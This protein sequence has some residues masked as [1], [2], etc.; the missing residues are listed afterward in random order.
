MHNDEQLQNQLI[1]Q[2]SCLRLHKGPFL[3]YVR[4][5]GW[6]CGPENGNFPL[7][8]VVKMSLR[9]WVVQ[10]SLK[11]PLHNIK[12]ASY[13]INEAESLKLQPKV[14]FN[15]SDTSSPVS[16]NFF[17]ALVRRFAVRWRWCCGRFH[18]RQKTLDLS[19]W[20]SFYCQIFSSQPQFYFFRFLGRSKPNIYCIFRNYKIILKIIVQEVYSLITVRYPNRYSSQSIFLRFST[21]YD[22]AILNNNWPC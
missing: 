13:Y 5:Q 4:T 12:M 10:K 20:G 15:Y 21:T 14:I 7:L 17:L 6:V 19:Y 9:R 8:Y 3:Y 1:I 18:I 2:L 16:S 11:T 22:W